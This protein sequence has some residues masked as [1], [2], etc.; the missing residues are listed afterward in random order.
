MGAANMSESLTLSATP[1]LRG[2]AWSLL[3]L[4]H[5]P[6]IGFAIAQGGFG[7]ALP[8]PAEHTAIGFTLAVA[9]CALQLRHSIA[10]ASGIRPR[11][12][13]LTLGSLLIIAYVPF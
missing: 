11:C 12:R 3:V 5:V 4:M 9:G 6:F 8:G 13:R 1:P 7:L 2:R 10:F